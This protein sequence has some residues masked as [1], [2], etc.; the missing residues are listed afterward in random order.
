MLARR[1][2]DYAQYLVLPFSGIALGA[3]ALTMRG[4]SVATAFPYYR[5]FAGLFI[6]ITLERVWTY[7][8]AVPQR[9]MLW[10]DLTSTAVQ[11]FLVGGVFGTIVLPVLHY[12]PQTFLGRRLLFGLSDQL[13]PLWVQ[14]IA[15]FLLSS[16]WGYWMH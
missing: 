11:T 15:V 14:V 13:C 12:F 9:H 4:S 5:S 7:R 10:R 8:H 1:F 2:R 16:F 6:M 3:I